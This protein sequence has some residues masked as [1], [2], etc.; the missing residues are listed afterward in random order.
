MTPRRVKLGRV[1][2]LILLLGLPLGLGIYRASTAAYSLDRLAP[3]RAFRVN[4]AIFFNS[5]A[6][7]LRVQAHLPRNESDL[8]L[9]ARWTD[10][11]LI[12]SAESYRGGNR[13]LEWWGETE[14]S[15]KVETSF[16]AIAKS[17]TY[18]IDPAFTVPGPPSDRSRSYLEATETIQVE[19]DEI[20]TLAQ[21]LAPKGSSAA[22]ALKRIYSYCAAL[23]EKTPAVGQNGQPP[24]D[25]LGTLRAQSASHLGRSRLFTAL[26]RHRG[27]PTRVVR[28]LIIG[29]GNNL[30]ETSW[31][32]TRLGGSWVPFCPA[33]GLFARTGGRLIPFCRGDVPIVETDPPAQTRIRFEADRTFAVRGKLIEGTGKAGRNWLGIWGA[34]EESG[35]SVDILCIV[36]MLPFGAFVSVLLRNVLGLRT[37]GF[38]LP[39][40]IA[41][42]AMRAG[43]TWAIAGLLFVIGVVFLF[44]L[45]A[46]P[47][48]VLHYPRLAAALT[49]TVVAVMG[50]A[51]MGA[52]TGNLRLA[53]VTYL[54]VV[55]LTI[56][57]EQFSRIMDE[58]GSLEV[59]KV[60]GMTIVAIGLS[61]LVMSNYALQR[62]VLTFPEIFLMLIFL[63][64]VIGCWTGMRL[65]E[66][67]RFRPL[68]P[69]GGAGNHA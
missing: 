44:R 35:V 41:V 59:V 45:V 27:F 42:A 47:L 33:S 31:A 49:T 66:F 22:E 40:L 38:F 8:S 6:D 58:E 64:I 16:S 5:A 14:G 56:A 2:V 61:Y 37:F 60:I 43:L 19:D 25:A 53:H 4:L 62:I 29:N 54:P 30:T 18:E 51:A 34:L 7:T 3:N 24:E 50:L 52:M 46:N 67:L 68:S 28:G 20:G 69:T 57:T 36:L 21:S 12:N 65:S 32:E 17:V 11:D 55:V 15:G 9:G 48:R 10:T 63:D 39:T 13:L 26:A 1:L 23:P